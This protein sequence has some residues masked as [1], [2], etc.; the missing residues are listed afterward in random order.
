[1]KRSTIWILTVVMAIAL[2]G[3]LAMQIVYLEKMVAM[4][5]S[6]FSEVVMRSLYS[7]SRMLEQNETKYFLDKDLAEAEE[8]NSGISQNSFNFSNRREA[9]IDTTLSTEEE[10]T[11]PNVRPPNL[12]TLQDLNDSYQMKQETLK[13]LYLYQRGLLNEVILTIPGGRLKEFMDVFEAR[14]KNR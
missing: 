5:N 6:Q 7:V 8:M 9:A 3:L 12:P 2:L 4:R 11:N 1:M 13:G 14:H 10:E